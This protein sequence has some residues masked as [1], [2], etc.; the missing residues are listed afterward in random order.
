[1]TLSAAKPSLAPVATPPPSPT[2]FSS[3]GSRRRASRWR[4]RLLIAAGAV[5][6]LIVLR[7]TL[8]APDPIRVQAATAS[9]GAVE[10]TVTNTRAGTVKV[11][12]RTRLSPETSG[13]V[14]A[15]PFREGARVAAG[16]VVLRLDSSMQRAQLELANQDERAAD[17]RVEEACLA[18]DLAVRELARGQELASEG[19]ASRQM[20]ERLASENGRSA[21]ACRAAR[22]TLDQARARQRLTAEELARTELR[23][24]FTGIVAEVHTEIGE[25]ITPSP[26]GISLPPAVEILDPASVYVTAPIDEMDAERIRGAKVVRLSVDSRR[27]EHFAGHLVRI[28]P[29]VQDVVEQNRTLEVEAEFD[30]PAVAASLLPGTSADVEIIVSRRDAV[31]QVPTSAISQGDEVLVVE[32]DRLVERK[33]KVGL[34]NWRSSEILEGLDAGD[35]VVVTRNSPDIKSGARV[36]VGEAS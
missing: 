36:V 19:V 26:P 29:Y 6:L 17:A 5:A 30:D 16:D 28:A 33:V 11:R 35:K 21:A 22:A 4:R 24:P 15:I 25:W 7:L 31:L 23:A 9:M 10:E 12:N 18:A 13:R 2:P 8:L 32:G 3:N 34:R 14:I 1:V 20:L 27:G